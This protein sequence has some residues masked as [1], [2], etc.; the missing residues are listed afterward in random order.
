MSSTEEQLISFFAYS[1]FIYPVTNYLV[2]PKRKYSRWL[3]A[4]YAMLFLVAIS[5]CHAFYENRERGPNHYQLLNVRRDCSTSVLKKAYK[6]LS[7]EL[8]PDKNKSPT[9]PDEFNKVKH[10]YDILSNAENRGIYNRLGDDGVKYA[11]QA[12]VDQKYISIQL[13]VYYASSAIFAFFMTMSE[14]SGD[15]LSYSVFGL[16]AMLLFEA[17][18]VLEE[19]PIPSWI[20]PYHTP[21]G[22]I[23]LLHRIFPAYM[24][25]C[26]C[27][28]G[29]FYEDPIRSRYEALTDLATANRVLTQKA[30]N[31]VQSVWLY[32]AQSNQQT[33][34]SKIS[35]QHMNSNGLVKKGIIEYA[36]SLLR[37]QLEE[38]DEKQGIEMIEEKSLLVKNKKKLAA[39]EKSSSG[40]N[41]WIWL[42]NLAVYVVVFAMIARYGQNKNLDAGSSKK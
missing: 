18:I 24:N 13:L 4:V 35:L 3:G 38:T 19:T 10:A 2:S 6:K 15:A 11:S 37:H 25:G 1:M 8:H 22:M 21:Y 14:P 29:S 31:M 26:R 39:H 41:R 5:M 7:L 33:D 36:L 34:N 17:I 12:V 9:A 32:I 40:R 16:A 23:S 20:F 28:C 42:R 27:I 30:Y